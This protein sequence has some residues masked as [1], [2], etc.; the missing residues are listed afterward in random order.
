MDSRTELEYIV[1]S[2]DSY[3]SKLDKEVQCRTRSGT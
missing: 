1:A 3:R 2:D